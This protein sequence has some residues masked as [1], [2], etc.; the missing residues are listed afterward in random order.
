MFAYHIFTRLRFFHPHPLLRKCPESPL[1]KTFKGL[2]NTAPNKNIKFDIENNNLTYY[3]YENDL[4]GGEKMKRTLIIFIILG[5]ILATTG[6]APTIPDYERVEIEALIERYGNALL[7]QDHDLAKSCLAPGGP[8][9][10]NFELKYQIIVNILNTQPEYTGQTCSIPIFGV[11]TSQ[12]KV[13]G[14]WASVKL[15]SRQVCGFCE[16]TYWIPYP[17][18]VAEYAVPL[19]PQGS[20]GVSP[21][22]QWVCFENTFLVDDDTVLLKKANGQWLIY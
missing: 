6:C 11:K 15:E 1:G 21:F 5:F 22:N 9:E 14:E 18:P 19:P 2:I 16:N 12:I 3:F 10:Q 17:I 20:S 13:D 4:L 7:I 8:S